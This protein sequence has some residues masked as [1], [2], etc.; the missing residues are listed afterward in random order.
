LALLAFLVMGALVV[1]DRLPAG[2]LLLAGLPA[3]LFAVIVIVQALRGARQARQIGEF[4]D[5]E[6]PQVRWTYTPDEWAAL[7]EE[8]WREASGAWKLPAGCLAFLLGVAGLLV[9]AA[10]AQDAVFGYDAE[11]LLEIA[12]GGVAG[13]LVGALAGGLIGGVV[14]LG[15]WLAARQA[16]RQTVPGQAALGRQEFYTPD[17]YV[18]LDGDQAWVEQAEWDEERPGGLRRLQLTIGA[19]R[20]RRGEETWEIAVPE[21]VLAQVEEWVRQMGSGAD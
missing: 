11:A 20:G 15:N 6:R 1:L 3:A 9:G 12:A 19:Q 18:K 17:Q 13:A 16:Y 21:R 10:L 5:S 8:N 2:A 4:L 7:R 14:A